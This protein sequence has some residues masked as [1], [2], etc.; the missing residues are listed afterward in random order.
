GEAVAYWLAHYGRALPKS[1]KRGIADAA[2]RL[3]NQFSLGK[4]DR[5]SST[6]RFGD[7]IAL[8]HPRP[9]DDGQ[10]ALFAYA[11]AYQK[12]SSAEVPAVLTQIRN[13]KSARSADEVRSVLARGP[14]AIT[15][16]G[17]TW[18]NVSSAIGGM[19]AEDWE[20][21]IPT[22]G[23]MALLRNLRNF[24]QAGISVKAR[25]EVAARLSD[26]EQVAKSRQL[27]FRFL[28]AMT[29]TEGIQ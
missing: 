2:V 28:S 4:Y 18:E 25:K 22:M 9:R 7:V 13:R 14:E 15:A 29:A 8:T 16:A 24:A 11:R 1:V 5:K 19:T 10:A 3:Y 26:A 17:L 27:P 12:N 23:Y 6:V 20:A 21:A